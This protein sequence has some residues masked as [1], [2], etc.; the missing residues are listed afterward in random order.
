MSFEVFVT[1]VLVVIWASLPVS[2]IIATRD[3]DDE[4]ADDG[5]H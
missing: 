5:H 2:L 1:L 3:F 4:I